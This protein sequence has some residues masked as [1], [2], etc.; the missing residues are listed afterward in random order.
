MKKLGVI[1]LAALLLVP[2]MMVAQQLPD[3]FSR[4]QSLF[5]RA[6]RLFRDKDYFGAVDAYK[7]LVNGYKNSQYRDIY[8]YGLARSYYHVGDFA[9]SER[10]LATYHTLFPNSYLAPYAHH[11]KA[12]CEYRSGRLENA[13]RDYSAAYRGAGDARLRDLS[14]RSIMAAVEAGYFPPDSVL[15]LVPGDILCSVK[16]RMVYLKMGLWSQEEVAAF[17]SGCP[18]QMFRKPELPESSE[19]KISIGVMVPLSGPYA[20]YGQAILDGAMLAG[21]RL[22]EQRVPVEILAYDSR[23]D[24]V[25]AARE[26]IVLADAGVDAVIGPLLSNVAATTTA[27]LAARGIPQLVPAATQAGFTDLS[28]HCFQLSASI[29]TIG[30]GMAQYAVRHRGMTTLAVITPTSLDEMTIADAFIAEAERLGA[31]ILAYERFRPG[32]TDFGPYIKDIK[33]A[34]LGPAEDST[35]YITLEG[36]T[37]RPGEAPVSFDGLFVP[38]TEQQLF[39]LLPQLDFY[40]VHTSYLGTDEWNS[41]KVLKLGEKVLRDAVFYSSRAAM[42]HSRGYD[43]F[44]SAFDAKYGM[45]P[46]RL[47]AVGFDAL[48]LVADAYRQ[49]RRGPGDVSEFL[50]QVSAYDAASGRI[51]LGRTRSNVELPLF[52]LRENLV[53]PIVELPPV[54]E[55]EDAGV[56]PDSIG[57]QYIKYEY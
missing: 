31:T 38:A 8:N 28:P 20:K 21:D 35:F 6:Q 34:I 57:T 33:E 19:G 12:N 46:D 1:L 53:K 25:T 14:R 37:L 4:A 36:D 10:V 3:E 5:A 47:A 49:G 54:E 15:A 17:M 42:E 41:E 2:I 7:E 9:S 52:T 43:E 56:M 51:T 32:E 48:N 18:E 22:S 26:A 44:A 40:R 29:I 11:L 55:P 39:L 50:R 16:A 27:A 24:N 45:P 23:A 13:I 30:R